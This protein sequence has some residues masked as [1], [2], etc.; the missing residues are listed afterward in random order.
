MATTG[1]NTTCVTDPDAQLMRSGRTGMIIGYNVQASVDEQS[2]VVA[3]H[4]VT[5]EMGLQ[6]L[7]HNLQRVLNLK[8]A[9]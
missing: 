1:Y 2:G 5:A 6:V 3:H 4:T 9:E 8:G 7:A